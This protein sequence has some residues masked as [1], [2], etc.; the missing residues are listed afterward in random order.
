MKLTN[1]PLRTVRLYGQMGAKFGRVHHFALDTAAPSEAIQALI[2]QRPGFREYLM[3]AKD[4]GVG[5]A[6]FAGK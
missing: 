1:P 5:F 6:V 4:K 3:G 2:S